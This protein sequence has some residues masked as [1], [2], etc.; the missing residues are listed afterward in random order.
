MDFLYEYSLFLAK[1]ATIVIA[2]GIVIGLAAGAAMRNK[3][4]KGE[5]QFT[6][7]S[8]EFARLQT[9]LK[10][11]LMDKKV[12]K[13]W[14]KEQKKKEEKP[15][16]TTFVIDFHGSMG[17]SEVDALREEVTAVLAAADDGD[18]VLVRLESGGGVVHGY[19]LGASQLER[20]RQR[21]IELTVAVDKVAASGGYM[22]ACIANRIIAAPFAIIGSIGVLAQLPNF[23]RFLQKNDIDFE[24][25]TAGEYKRTVTLFGENTEKGREKFQQ[26]LEQ[27]HQLFKD[28]VYSHRD[29]LNMEQVATG[30][31]WLATQ[32]LEYK[33]VDVLQTSDDFILQRVQ[34]RR[35]LQVKFQPRKKLAER[36]G[37]GASVALQQMWQKLPFWHWSR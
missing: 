8:D 35:V 17:A 1:A 11:E 28:H 24:Q 4:K 34:Q 6:D 23:H 14:L 32:A 26:E 30:E 9:D 25:F 20:L 7:L 37:A 3:P 2:I 10:A 15:R 22:M 12:F 18:E 27:T 13:R 21:G 36:M 33:L 31:Y 19:G 29:V 5:F 16:Q